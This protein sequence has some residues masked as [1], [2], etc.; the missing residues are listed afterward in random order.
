MINKYPVLHFPPVLKLPT[1]CF[2]DFL[3]EKE[4]LKNIILIP[5]PDIVE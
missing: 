4:R 2:L 3:K 5:L 1:A